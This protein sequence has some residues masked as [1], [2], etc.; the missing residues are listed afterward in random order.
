MRDVDVRSSLAASLPRIPHTTELKFR[1]AS[2]LPSKRI[3]AP[4]LCVLLYLLTVTTDPSISVLSAVLNCAALSEI[5]LPT[6]LPLP[7]SLTD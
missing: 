3:F 6:V 5:K 1:H 7:H 4:S 2:K